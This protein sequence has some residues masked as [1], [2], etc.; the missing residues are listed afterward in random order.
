MHRCLTVQELLALIFSHLD[1][2]DRSGRHG[3]N[4]RQPSL[5]DLAVLAR[6]CCTFH[7]PALD[8]LWRSSTPVNLLRCMPADLWVVDERDG[9][10][11]TMLPRRPIRAEDWNRVFVYAPRIRN[12]C[13]TSWD[14]DLSQIFPVISVCLPD[15]LLPNLQTLHWWPSDVN[16]HFIHL[17][18]GPKITS[19]TFPASTIAAISLLPSLALKC[20]TL[21]NV[22]ILSGEKQAVSVF[23]RSL[24]RVESVHVDSLDHG[25]LEHLSRLPTLTALSLNIPPTS[26]SPRL[27]PQPFTV[28]RKLH[29]GSSH[30][31]AITHF[32]KSCKEVPL[33]SI[34]FNV[35]ICPTTAESH[36]FYRALSA[37]VL[38]SSLT[39][40]H[41]AVGITDSDGNSP[42]LRIHRE[43]IRCLLVFTNLVTVNISSPVGIDLDDT[44]VADLAR[45]WPHLEKL[46]LPSYGLCRSLPNTTLECLHSLATWCPHLAGLTITLDGTSA[47]TPPSPPSGISH[48]ALKLINV[49]HSRISTPI[50]PVARFLSAIFPA[51]K[52]IMTSRDGLDNED[53]DEL[54]L[55]GEAIEF[56]DLWKEVELLL[57]I[58]EAPAQNDSDG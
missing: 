21:K 58:Q 5:Q 42:N 19:I 7:E 47:P 6:T 29:L 34:D 27:D 11:C 50:M 30:I 53:E 39:E 12:L 18:L 35:Q 43:S 52:R 25:T 2:M 22:S 26:L 32:L 41:F 57:V 45:A 14:C 55:H 37:S 54:H 20:P 40:V 8:H 38:H 31:S 15:Q 46:L 4:S 13:F 44:T 17:F 24:K 23:L 51:L 28:L 49:A 1:P 10:K 3:Y 16:F 33:R 36:E 56:H 48:H 9:W